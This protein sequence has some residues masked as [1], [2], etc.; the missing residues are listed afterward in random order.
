MLYQGYELVSPDESPRK[1]LYQMVL[2]K[3]EDRNDKKKGQLIAQKDDD[4]HKSINGV[5]PIH[6]Y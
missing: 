6:L 4:E 3:I 2:N 5:S 1:K